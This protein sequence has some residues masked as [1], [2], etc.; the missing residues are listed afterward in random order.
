[1]NSD[2]VD[3]TLVDLQLGELT[4]H[5]HY[6]RPARSAFLFQSD[7]EERMAEKVCVWLVGPDRE[8]NFTQSGFLP[9][10]I[11]LSTMIPERY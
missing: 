9:S 5:E 4:E 11:P 6:H 7:S 8:C 2:E 10:T 3:R 1:L